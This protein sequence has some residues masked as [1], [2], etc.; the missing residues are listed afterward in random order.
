MS[1]SV[2]KLLDNWLERPAPAY[3][4]IGSV[5]SDKCIVAERFAQALL[6]QKTEKLNRAHPDLVLIDLEEGEKIISV[7]AV[8]AAR[9]RLAQ[10]PIVASRLVAYLPCLER[11]NEEGLNALLKVLEEPPAG[12]VF[13][14]A[15]EDLSKISA[16]VQ[17]RMV[18]ISFSAVSRA[19]LPD[20][21]FTPRQF[22][23][24][25]S[26]GERL[27]LIEAL[28]KKCE[29]SEFAPEAWHQALDEWGE[30]FRRA[31]TDHPVTALVAAQGVVTA[32]RFIG[33]ALSP[34]LPL[35]AAALRLASSDPLHD[36]FPN[37]IPPSIPSIFKI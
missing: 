16:T 22:L 19:I 4:F 37:P 2:F 28:S 15:A 9:S 8:R 7:E 29:S 32:Y 25:S 12:A 35:E 24:A 34:R 30:I 3:L 31:L 11:L 10:R 20:A 27:A 5:H 1:K 21:E 33:G 36:L 26:T 6:G 13:V 18:K 14:A 23:R 17:S